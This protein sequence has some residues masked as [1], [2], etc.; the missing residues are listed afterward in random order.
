GPPAMPHRRQF[1]QAA[2][3]AAAIARPAA[4]VEPVRRAGR[5]PLRLSLA[6][7]SFNRHLRLGGKAKPSMTLEDFVDFTAEPGF[8]AAELTAYY[9]PRTTAD[10]LARLKGRCT[11]LGLD[12]SG[13]AV[14]N[15]FCV[16]AP[17]ALQAQLASVKAWVEH[18]SRLGAK[19][20][21]IFA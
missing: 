4:A 5:A 11:R 9:F 1:L 13:T 15:D 17:A 7:Y 19:T 20:M 21:R 16:Q 3:A 18:S 2:L 6:A 10:Y 14:G 8:D 12:V